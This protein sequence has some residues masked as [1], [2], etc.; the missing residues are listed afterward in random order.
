MKTMIIYIKATAET[1]KIK[2]A[3]TENLMF[4]G[5][6]CIFYTYMEG[7]PPLRVVP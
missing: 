1:L 5:A 7:T 6:E 3:D 4:S 2:G